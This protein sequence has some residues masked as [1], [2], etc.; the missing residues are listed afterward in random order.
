M[1]LNLSGVAFGALMV[2]LV[3]AGSAKADSISTADIDI[4]SAVFSNGAT[5]FHDI[6]ISSS[7]NTL[8]AQ[9][10]LN[11][12]SSA[13]SA[14]Q[15]SITSAGIETSAPNTL[16]S[17]GSTSSAFASIN[18][19]LFGVNPDGSAGGP[20][21]V[22]HADSAQNLVP[23]AQGASGVTQSGTSIQ[24]TANATLSTTLTL[25]GSTTFFASTTHQGETASANGKLTFDLL[26]LTSGLDQVF[27]LVDN[28][29]VFSLAAVDSNVLHSLNVLDPTHPQGDPAAQSFSNVT[30]GFGVTSGD[31]YIF[32]ITEN[33]ATN[34]TA[35]PEPGTLAL[36]GAG[37]A[38]LGFLGFRR[39]KKSGGLAA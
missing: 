15:G 29:G 39:Q 32:S 7:S 34:A 10:S 22:T 9:T 27:S 23:T 28:N 24:F 25:S 2:G 5:L 11:G 38:G 18:G 3:A 33:V 16:T 12:I 21:A 4:S 37:L 20:A 8:Q 19:N 13:P 31:L 35:V 14:T 36:F 1:K 26:D 6:T 30:A 17:G